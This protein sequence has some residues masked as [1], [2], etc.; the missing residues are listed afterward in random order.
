MKLYIKERVFSWGDKFDVWDEN[1]DVQYTV[2]GE[3]FTWGKKLHVYDATGRERIYIQQELL[4]WM[5]C[6][7]IFIDGQEALQIRRKFTF[8][9]PQYYIEGLNWQID[10]DYFGHN[11]RIT[12]NGRMVAEIEK[13]WMRWGD[14]YELTFTDAT[15]IL[16]AL[17]AII[18]IDCIDESNNDT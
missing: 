5:P 4:T 18:T 1:G 15:T 8:F 3:V 16:P 9:R 6:Y 11:Y 17:A 2:A 10:G 12:Q 14:S 13:A 7:H